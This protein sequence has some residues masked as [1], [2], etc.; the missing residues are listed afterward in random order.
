M[1]NFGPLDWAIVAIYLVGTAAVGFYVKRYIRNMDDYVV[2]GRALR[3]RLAVASLVGSELGL[4]TVMYSSQKGFT[5]GLAALHIG[6]IAGIVT[7]VIGF[8]G[9]IVVPLR[10]L[11]VKPSGG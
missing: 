9:F 5:G 8:T 3:S 11:G 10:A 7:L 6:L 4:V 2:A 1:T